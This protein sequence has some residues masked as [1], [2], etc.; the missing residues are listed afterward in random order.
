MLPMGRYTIEFNEEAERG[1]ETD[2]QRLGV[3]SKTEVIRKAIN[4]LHFVLEERGEGAKLILENAVTNERKE[5]A[6][7]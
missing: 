5:V 3:A 1:L 6:P 2:R 4:L 7:L